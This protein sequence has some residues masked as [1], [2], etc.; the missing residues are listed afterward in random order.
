PISAGAARGG[1]PCAARVDDDRRWKAERHA[2]RFAQPDPDD[3]QAR[4]MNR[5]ATPKSAAVAGDTAHVARVLPGRDEASQ[6]GVS[7][8]PRPLA[9]GAA[10]R[11][12]RDFSRLPTHARVAGERARSTAA[13]L[14]V[15]ALGRTPGIPLPRTIQ[16]EASVRYGRSFAAVRIHADAPASAAAVALNASAFTLGHDIGFRAGGYAPATPE[17]QLLLQHELRHVA[18]QHAAVPASPVQIDASESRHERQARQILD[19]HVD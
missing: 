8:P 1:G 13:E 15:E 12:H 19:P 5:L 3:R 9:H 6:K 14:A 11:F 17:G 18:Q 7:A 10:P 2:D 16:D 4:G